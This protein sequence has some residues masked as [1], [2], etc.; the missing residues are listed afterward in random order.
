MLYRSQGPNGQFT[1]RLDDESGAFKI[2][3][4]TGWL[5]VADHR[6]LDRET[7]SSLTVFITAVE[8]TPSLET[9][10]WNGSSKA[11]I[12]INLIDSNDNNPVF[13]PGDVYSF[14]VESDAEPGTVIGQVSH[15]TN[16][17]SKAA[18]LFQNHQS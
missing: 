4:I 1:Y 8:Y 2:D 9:Q 10:L 12:D 6:Q 3:P 15:V 5:S 7:R 16:M 18:N 11:R 14:T 17:K 13:Q